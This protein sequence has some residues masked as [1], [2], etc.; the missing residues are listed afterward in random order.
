MGFAQLILWLED[1]NET[2]HSFSISPEASDEEMLGQPSQQL[3][4]GGSV[5]LHG[6]AGSAALINVSRLHTVTIRPTAAT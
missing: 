2:T 6:K 3:A 4:R 1:V 5:E